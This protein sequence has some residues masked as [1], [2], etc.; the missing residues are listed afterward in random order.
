MNLSRLV[1]LLLS[2]ALSLPV[3][4][5]ESKEEIKKE[6]RFGSS[7]SDNHLT[8]QNI[9]GSISI[10]GY[11]GSSIQVS[12]T[13]TI[14][15]ENGDALNKGKE[16]V[17][18]RFAEK[19]NK[20]FVYLETPMNQYDVEKGKYK[21][22]DDK[23]RK[24]KRPDYQYL[25]DITIR[26]PR[27]SSLKVNTMNDGDILIKD[28]QAK[29]L[30]VGN[31]NGAIN[32]ENVAGKTYVNALNKD[33]NIS[34]ASNPT[35]ESVFKSLNGDINIQLASSLDADVSFKSLNGDFYTN[36]EATVVPQKMSQTRDSSGKTKYKISKN[37][38][39]KLGSGGVKY[40]FDLLNGDVMLKK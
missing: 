19:G 4:A 35:E 12:A 20:V 23:N 21:D 40:R 18:L 11:S 1:V 38:S 8:V 7:S 16:E 3:F 34:Y 5:Q 14:K 31:L 15:G 9:N 13:K 28:V 32:M 37:E 22:W 10:E 30:H 17:Q 26:V 27:S 39:F 33:I 2:T 36:M 6:L 25:L 29:D 24:Y